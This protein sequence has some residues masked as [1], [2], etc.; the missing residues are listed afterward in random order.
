MNQGYPQQGFVPPPQKKSSGGKIALII[1]AVVVVLAGIGIFSASAY[2]TSQGNAHATATAQAQD[3][4]ATAN[5]QATATYMASHFPFSSKLILNDSLSGNNPAHGWMSDKYCS[6]SNNMYH[7]SETKSSTFV[8][9]SAKSTDYTDFSFEA[10]MQNFI[11]N[12]G[13][14]VFRGDEDQQNYYLFLVFYDGSFGF[15]SYSTASHTKK[16]IT[17]DVNNFSISKPIRLGVTAQGNSFKFFADGQQIG[18]A[19]DSTYSHGQVGIAVDN[20]AL[21]TE[22]NF[23]NAKVWQL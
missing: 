1:L 6:F 20:D 9:C 14:L 7:A 10:T 23:S 3:A 11:G 19:T 15:Y 21:I 4:K 17:G 2:N 12:A 8:T 5:V 18:Q 13:G 22:A 16:I